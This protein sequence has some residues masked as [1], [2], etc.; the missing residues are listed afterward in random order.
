MRHPYS[1]EPP[2][3]KMKEYIRFLEWQ[4]ARD[5]AKAKKKEEHDKKK[6]VDKKSS[7]Q[8]TF[9][10]GMIIAYILQIVLPPMWKVVSHNMGIQ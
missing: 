2:P 4:E 6:T 5:E 9:A 3:F 7:R 8:M 1:F 10:E